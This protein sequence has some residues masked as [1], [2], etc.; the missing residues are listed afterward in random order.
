MLLCAAFAWLLAHLSKE[1]PR[2][3]TAGVS[4]I[5][6]VIRRSGQ[7][8]F[9][10]T[11]GDRQVVLVPDDALRGRS[12]ASSDS[13]QDRT[14]K[15]GRCRARIVMLIHELDAEVEALSHV[16]LEARGASENVPVVVAAS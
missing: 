9:V 1:K 6:A 2:R 4:R 12:A 8:V 3:R 15:P 11:S 16:P 10:D 14:S 13:A 7:E 5:Q